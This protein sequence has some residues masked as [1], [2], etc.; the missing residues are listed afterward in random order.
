MRPSGLRVFAFVIG[1]LVVTSAAAQAQPMALSTTVEF[2][3]PDVVMER[4]GIYDVVR[5]QDAVA[6]LEV[7]FPELPLRIVTLA[8]PEGTVAVRADAEVLSE[9]RLAGT[10]SIRPVQPQVPLSRPDLARWVEPDPAAYASRSPYPAQV[11]ALLGNGMI[12]GRPVATV[13]VYPVRYA[14]ADGSL[15]LNE[16]VRID[17]TLAPNE[18]A[19]SAQA[20]RRPA[21]DRAAVE[22]LRALV[23]N[24]EDV[25]LAAGKRGTRDADAEYLIITSASLASIFQPLADWKTRKGVPAQ[26]LTTTWIYSNYTGVDNQERIRNCIIDYY[27]NHG[28]TWVLLGGDTGI[29]PARVVYAMTSGVGGSPD[30]DDIRCDLYYADL[31]GTWNADGDGTWGEVTQ[32]AIDMYAD[33]FIG[34]APVDNTTEASRFVSK[35]LTYQGA[36]GAGSPPTDYQRKALFLA[37]VLWDTPFTDGGICKDM[38]DDESV[39]P[40]LDPISKLY[41]TNGLLTKSRAISEMNAGRNIVNH[42]GHANYNV[43][44]I[45][46]GALYGSDFDNLANGSR[47]GIFYSIGC[48]PAAIDYDAIGEHWVHAAHAG[49]AFVGN[50]RYGWG[51]PGNPGSGTSDQFDREFFRQLFN[52]GIDRI[53]ATHAAHKDAMVGLAQTSEYYRYCLYEL[54]LLGDPEMTVWTVEPVFATAHHASEAPLGEHTFVVTVMRSG[55]PVGG[56]TVHLSSAE[57]SETALTGP[58]GIAVLYPAPTV[59]GAMT[60]TVTGQGILPYSASI[61]VVDEPADTESPARVEELTVADPFDVGGT[62]ELSWAGYAAP[63]DFAYYRVYR[64]TAAFSDVSGLTPITGGILTPENTAWTDSQAGNGVPYWYAVTAVDLSGN[65][66]AAV[67]CRGPVAATQNARILVWD[68]DDGDKPFD[69]IGDDFTAADGC[70]A[71]WIDALDAASELYIVSETLPE[72]LAAFDFVIYLGG[73]IQYAGQG[74]VNI[75]MT[76]A[77]AEAITAFID[78]GGSVYVEEPS[79]GG[80]YYVSG[81]PATIALWNRFHATHA[82]GSGRTIG[83]VVSLTGVP[84][85]PSDGKSFT[86]DYRNWP[87]QFVGRVGPNGDAGASQL[88]SDQSA[89]SR[90]AVY[91]APGAGA[92]LYMVPVLLGGMTDGTHPSTRAEYVA[93]ILID[94]DLV[95]TSGVPETPAVLTNRLEHNAPNPFN[96]ATTIRYSVGHDGARVRLTVYDVTGRLVTVLADGAAAAGEHTSRWDGRD[97]Q[98]R[99]VSSGVYFCRLTVDAWTSSMKMT[100]LK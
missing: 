49:V 25:L 54:N 45:G 7:G 68:A 70:E 5:M 96:P 80:T 8:L 10:Y 46:P 50:S 62:I 39:P 78:G 55:E 24:P 43:L 47:Y 61:A 6:T 79:F 28:T 98:G 15:T 2:A 34:R 14:P 89:N 87:D 92:R 51:S 32:D 100:L 66:E 53:G 13:A 16:T 20:V 38:I 18:Q 71:P 86:Y 94:L 81:T 26:V 29:V 74:G 59:E 48:W 69:G 65:E 42:M 21:N 99:A 52:E 77:D 40:E 30:E 95:G 44:S 85:Q 33:L 75:P 17:L 36:T 67:S 82:A 1:A 12:G 9:A 97:A 27:E 35:T 72:E 90:G 88:W 56:A 19:S 83:N 23:A 37:E 41:E 57:V 93:R 63:A 60:M 58:D 84:G 3:R 31:D 4:A 91:A 22:R 11:C 76:D 64:G 73:V